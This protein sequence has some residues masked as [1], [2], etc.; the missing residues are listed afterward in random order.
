MSL[1]QAAVQLAAPWKDA[2]DNSTLLA[3]SVIAL[4]LTAL[5][6]GGGLA[7]A[8]DR[9][10]LRVPGAAVGG[11]AGAAAAVAAG[12]RQ[13][14]LSELGA[15]HRPVLAALV[16]LFVSGVA[17]TLADLETYIASSVYWLKF[18]LIV[19]L[20]ANGV[21]MTRTERALGSSA[22][23]AAPV[24]QSLWRRMR[25][26]AWASIALWIATLV[27]GTALVNMA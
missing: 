20:L 7:I 2:Y 6:V 15:V 10:T 3:T 24:A 18:A 11:D 9:A 14:Q 21:V 22:Q 25:W 5:L 23:L 4:H 26:S 8:A 17:L 27:L 16:I 19:L 1:L 13:R 12:E